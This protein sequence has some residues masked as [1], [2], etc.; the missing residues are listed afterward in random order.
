MPL[1][2]VTEL[3]LLPAEEVIASSLSSFSSIID[4]TQ[5]IGKIAVTVM[6]TYSSNADKANPCILE[7]YSALQSTGPFDNVPIE[8]F[9]IDVINNDTV[10]CTK[11]FPAVS[12]Y[13]CF[14][15]RN[16]DGN[17]SVTDVTVGAVY[18]RAS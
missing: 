9:T 8:T 17:N 5:A 2:K 3:T 14:A 12:N 7:V 11:T 1:T 10:V 16:S 15:V 13:Y 4:A 6:V 18:Q